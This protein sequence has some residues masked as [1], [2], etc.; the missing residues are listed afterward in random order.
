MIEH[1]ESGSRVF[2]PRGNSKPNDAQDIAREVVGN[3][4]EIND[5]LIKTLRSRLGGIES[6]VW[7]LDTAIDSL[8]GPLTAIIAIL[9]V[10]MG[11]AGVLVWGMLR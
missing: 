2:D 7:N 4:D 3:T 11:L 9:V 8:I 5:E 10:L 1:G 6:A